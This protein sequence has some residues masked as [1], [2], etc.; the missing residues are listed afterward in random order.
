MLNPLFQT[1]R[2][3][4]AISQINGILLNDVLADTFLSLREAASKQSASG[5]PGYK[6]VIVRQRKISIK[7]KDAHALKQAFCIILGV[8]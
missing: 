3:D 7:Q 6:N 8:I 2:T 1:D 4:I 5:G